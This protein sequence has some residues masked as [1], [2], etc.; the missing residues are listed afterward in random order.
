[1]ETAETV[2]TNSRPA[3][4]GALVGEVSYQA[5][6]EQAVDMIAVLDRE[7]RLVEVNPALLGRLGYS[8]QELVGRPVALILAP[9]EQDVAAARLARKFDGAELA[10]LYEVVLLSKDGC[11]VPSDVSSQVI[12]RDELPV[13]VLVIA[14]DVSERVAA[15]AALE[16]S[17]RRAQG[18][19][20]GV[21]I[22]MAFT[23]PAGT[24]LRVNAAYGRCSATACRS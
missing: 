22:G 10:S 15:L 13:G 11:R 3:G 8:E 5:L 14:R 2:R 9:G 16:E 21:A 18:A 12:V 19:F 7:G 20:D 24:L 1:M 23:D 4:Q 17:E 6:F